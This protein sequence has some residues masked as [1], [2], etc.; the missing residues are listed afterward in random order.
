MGRE[1]QIEEREVLGSIFPD[2]ITGKHAPATI[3]S[4]SAG[5]KRAHLLI[6]GTTDISDTEFRISI[7]LD[8]PND[9]DTGVEPR[10]SF[11]L[12]FSCNC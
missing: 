9:D 12:I 10:S 4:K 5:P 6:N 1:D 7:A 8:I 11:Y 2:E 3:L